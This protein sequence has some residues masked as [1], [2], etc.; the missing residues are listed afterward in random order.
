MPGP[1][2]LTSF[3]RGAPGLGS[4]LT[5]SQD[6][7]AQCPSWHWAQTLHWLWPFSA[8]GE[9]CSHG[10]AGLQPRIRR[11]RLM[12][13]NDIDGDVSGD[14]TSAVV[15]VAMVASLARTE[16]SPGFR[17]RWASSQGPVTKVG[18]S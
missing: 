1:K 9:A 13:D 14:L 15:A 6:Q 10:E 3:Q 5:C 7:R 18:S 12:G 16:P 11:T 2:A 17:P 8:G 4:S